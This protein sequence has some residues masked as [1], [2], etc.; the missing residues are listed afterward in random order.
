M[1][2]SVFINEM[3]VA[4][5]GGVDVAVEEWEGRRSKIHSEETKCERVGICKNF[6]KEKRLFGAKK[7]C[8]GMVDVYD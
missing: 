2:R 1:A 3:N 8:G 7:V 4:V 6:N 5:G